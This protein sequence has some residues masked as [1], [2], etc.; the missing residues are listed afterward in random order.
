MFG[1]SCGEGEEMSQH[2]LQYNTGLSPSTP[3]ITVLHFIFTKQHLY[4][5]ALAGR[6]AASP[7]AFP[8]YNCQLASATGIS[9]F[10]VF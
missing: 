2:V 6:I 9:N 7:L 5:Q 10:R 3:F 8:D 4:S 1:E